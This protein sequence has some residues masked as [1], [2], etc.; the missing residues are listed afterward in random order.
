MVKEYTYKLQGN[1]KDSWTVTEKDDD[2]NII[3]KYMVYEKP[4][5]FAASIEEALEVKK[6]QI[7]K[8]TQELIFEGFSFAGLHWSLSINAQINWN[9][10]PQLP[11]IVFP[12]AIQDVDGNNYNLEYSDRMNFYYTAVNI[13]NSHLQSGNILKTQVSQLTNIT[14]ILNFQDPR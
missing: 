12:L 5:G 13:K 11:E 8:R 6:D 4:D 10:L 9:N 1:G 14:E 3:N 7:D 2:G